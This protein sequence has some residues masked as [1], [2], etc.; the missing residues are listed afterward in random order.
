M[1]FLS[2]FDWKKITPDC[3]G[4][5]FMFGYYDRCPWNMADDKHLAL[6]IPVLP[7]RLPQKGEQ[8]IVGYVDASGEFFP[9]VETRA[10]CYQQGCMELFLTH[11]P[12]CFIYNDYDETAKKIVARI[13]QL[14]KGIVGQYNRGIYAISPN[15]KYGVALNFSRIPRRGYSYAWAE[16]SKDRFPQDLD[17]DGIWLVDL[18]SG[19]ERLVVTYRAMLESHPYAYAL[20][21]QYI[22]LNHAIFNSDSTRLLWLFRS[23]PDEVSPN[24]PWKTYMYTSNIDGSNLK[25]SLPAVYWDHW[26]ISHQ[27]WG[28]APSE[29][30]VDA[31]WDGTGYHAISYND[32]ETP[33]RARKISD[34]HGSMSHMVYSPDGKWILSDSYP[35]ADSFQKVLLINATTGK[36]LLLGKFRQNAPSDTIIDKRCDLHPRWNHAGDTVTIDS[37]DSGKRA[38]YLLNLQQAMQS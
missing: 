34:G 36:S 12:D 38:I 16:L 1:S 21:N 17:G 29:I 22:W 31:N 25:C 2:D 35:D 11:R 3:D 6:K 28:H 13:Y 30:L 20:E 8:A 24:V 33:F 32:D 7:N 27:I 15:G 37:I 5:E 23:I 10:W 4:Y 14:N 18:E 26:M 9:Q 19:E